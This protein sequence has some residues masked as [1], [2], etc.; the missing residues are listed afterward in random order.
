MSPVAPKRVEGESEEDRERRIRGRENE[1]R[2]LLNACRDTEIEFEGINKGPTS[3]ECRYDEVIAVPHI[4][5]KIKEAERDG[6][7]AVIVNGFVD[8]GVR[9]GRELV[10]IPVVGPGESSMLTAYSICDRFSIVTMVKSFIPLVERNAMECGTM[11]KLASIRAIEIPVLELRSDTGK[12]V[13][14][15]AE[16]GGK[17]V[18]QDGAQAVILGC[19]GMTGMAKEV[20]ALL[21]VH[22]IDPL[23]AAV[24]MAE[25]LISLGLSQS[26]LAYMRPPEKDRYK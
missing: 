22:V 19:T 5:E 23:P 3:V 24:K 10:N 25:S 2:A 21:G 14:A 20:E 9:A 11:G 15:L 13:S 4:V 1:R 26:R 7:D 12:T 8:P 6:C 17:A 18:D 16:A